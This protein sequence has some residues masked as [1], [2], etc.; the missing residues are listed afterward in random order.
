[1]SDLLPAYRSLTSR[2]AA[3]V[4]L[5]Q[6]LTMSGGFLQ[7]STAFMGAPNVIESILR[8]GVDRPPVTA[9]AYSDQSAHL[10]AAILTSATGQPLLRYAR[11]RL[12]DPLGIDTRPARTPTATS[13]FSLLDV[14]RYTRSQ[15]GFA[16]PRD[17]QGIYLGY[18]LGSRSTGRTDHRREQVPSAGARCGRPGTA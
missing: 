2:Q 7:D 3:D 9:F 16:W 18:A 17:R 4:T 8:Y 11:S 1:M 12:F 10:V 15:S 14:P 5:R 6:L 13:Y